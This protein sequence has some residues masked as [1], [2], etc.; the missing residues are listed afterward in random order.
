MDKKLV[1][2]LQAQMGREAEAAQLYLGLA[3]WCE[4]AGFDGCAEYLRSQSR[5]ERMHMTRFGAFLRNYVDVSVELPA[6]RAVLP[7]VSSLP[8]VFEAVLKTEKAVTGWIEQLAGVACETHE[9]AVFAWL[10]WFLEE[11]VRS[12]E[13]ARM[14]ADKARLAG[15]DPAALLA[16]D[17][18]FRA[19][20][21]P[22]VPAG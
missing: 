17:G 20:Y 4:G 10:H 1:E 9:W 11:Q 12:V 3:F 6:V 2:L 21:G 13:E 19:V 16:F 7:S 8:Q 15:T 18:E 22:P 14:N 5:D